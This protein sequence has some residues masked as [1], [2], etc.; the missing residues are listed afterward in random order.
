[1][2]PTRP[3]CALLNAKRAVA[4]GTSSGPERGLDWLS[5]VIFSDDDSDVSIGHI[6][7]AVI[8]SECIQ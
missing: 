8:A 1:M 7:E 6:D 3:S 4:T 2:Y 5:G